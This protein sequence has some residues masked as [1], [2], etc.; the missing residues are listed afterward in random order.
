MQKTAA[1]LRE[2]KKKA[3]AAAKENLQLLKS[4][5]NKAGYLRELY[6]KRKDLIER[7]ENRKKEREDYNKRGTL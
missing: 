7:M 4:S 2:E 1:L 3:L 6:I 5:E